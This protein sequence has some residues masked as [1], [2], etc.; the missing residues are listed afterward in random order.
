MSGANQ[1]RPIFRRRRLNY[2]R[3]NQETLDALRAALSVPG[4]M[5]PGQL[6]EIHNQTRIPASNLWRWRRA[7]LNGQDPFAPP[8]RRSHFSLPREIE[9]QIYDQVLPWVDGQRFCPPAVLRIMALSLA[10]PTHPD[11]RAGHGWIQGFLRRYGLSFRTSHPRRRTPANDQVIASFLQEFEIA[12]LQLSPNLI[13][14]MDETAWRLFHGALRTLARRGAEE[15]STRSRLD[16]KDNLTVICTVSLAGEKLPPWVIVKGKTDRCEQRYRNDQRLRSALAGKLWLTHSPNGWA[17]RQVMCEYLAWLSERVD[18]DWTYLVW[19]L[20][21]SHRDDSVKTIARENHVNLA[22]IPAGQTS[23]WQPL[24]VKVF[25]ALKAHARG[26]LNQRC[27]QRSLTSIDMIDALLILIQAWDDLD[28]ETVRSSWAN[29][30]CSLL[31]AGFPDA[32]DE[33]PAEDEIEEED[34]EETE[35]EEVDDY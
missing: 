6:Q 31:E 24:D 8:R 13:F 9:D 7:L 5:P 34:E 29:I 20:H 25:G 27:A 28:R 21:A 33:E 32:E 19:D 1:L 12:K 16:D 18:H 3:L 35:N 22:Y 17:T 4:R 10:R 30:G 11:F 14:N 26:L 23:M 2:R 15:V